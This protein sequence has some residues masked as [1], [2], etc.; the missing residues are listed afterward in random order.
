MAD[1]THKLQA[2]AER[3]Q[4]L[5]EEEQRLIERRKKE[6]GALAERLGLLTTSDEVFTGVLLELQQ[7]QQKQSSQLVEWEQHGQAYL[8]PKNRPEASKKSATTSKA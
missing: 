7:A 4:R 8:T 5:L 3:K 6:I 1:Y 2:L